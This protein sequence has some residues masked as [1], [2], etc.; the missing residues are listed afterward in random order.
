MN[1]SHAAPDVLDTQPNELVFEVQGKNQRHVERVSIRPNQ[2]INIGRAWNNTIIVQDQYVDANHLSITMPE[3]NRFSVAD[4]NTLNGSEVNGQAVCGGVQYCELNQVIRIGDTSITIHDANRPVAPA[5][6]RSAWFSP[7]LRSVSIG[8]I[9]ALTFLTI[10]IALTE[11]WLGS[12]KEYQ[13]RDGATV[14]LGLALSFFVWVVLFGSMGKLL[15]AES[16]MKIHWLLCCAFYIIL[17]LIFAVSTI[18][19]FNT[20]SMLASQ[21]FSYALSSVAAI[22]F[23]FGTLSVASNLGSLGRWVWSILLVSTMLLSI[24]SNS[25]FLKEHQRWSSYSDKKLVA[26][27]DFLLFRQASSVDAHF[28]KV[29]DLFEFDE[30][31]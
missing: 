12:V 25:L 13:F 11:S 29:D 27:P 14:V 23:L 30:L 24:H 19:H 31:N 3:Q 8:S 6:E 16:N 28:D 1:E 21:I 2:T 10:V 20:H 26:L 5:L 9:L 18:V 15:R 4:N 17:A 7:K 22:I